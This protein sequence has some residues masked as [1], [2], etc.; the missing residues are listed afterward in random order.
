MTEDVVSATCSVDVAGEEGQVNFTSIEVQNCDIGLDGEFNYADS[1]VN[2]GWVYSSR[3]PAPDMSGTSATLGVSQSGMN[4]EVQC[5]LAFFDVSAKMKLSADTAIQMFI[6]DGTD[7]I[8]ASLT[9]DTSGAAT[10]TA[11]VIAYDFSTGDYIT[12]GTVALDEFFIASIVTNTKDLTVSINVDGQAVDVPFENSA[13][14]SPIS[15]VF[16]FNQFG[17]VEFD[18]I[19]TSGSGDTVKDASTVQTEIAFAHLDSCTSARD[20]S[21]DPPGHIINTSATGSDRYLYSGEELY[22]N[23][24]DYCDR[25]TKVE[26]FF[27]ITNLGTDL[28][29]WYAEDVCSYTELADAVQYNNECWSEAFA[30]CVDVTY[31][32]DQEAATR[33]ADGATVC[34]GILGASVPST[35]LLGPLWSAAW[36]LALE[37]I[38]MVIFLVF[39]LVVWLSLK[40]LR[41]K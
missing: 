29:Y 30:Y 23:I 10:G 17:T 25:I 39:V 32:A 31:A 8:I 14:T 4:H 26:G 20:F 37:N 24:Q 41:R 11:D 7:N 28:D 19:R 27:G 6:S 1:P 38:M 9:F 2:H 12:F 3:N 16:V 36:R 18:Y 34:L 13:F 33:G 21:A 35:R 40:G 5:K 15:K 22:P